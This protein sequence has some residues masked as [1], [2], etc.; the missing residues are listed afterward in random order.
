[1]N[2]PM[3]QLALCDSRCKWHNRP[4]NTNAHFAI[5]HPSIFSFESLWAECFTTL[6][7][8]HQRH[9]F[10]SATAPD[11]CC[12]NLFLEYAILL[13]F[14]PTWQALFFSWAM[15]YLLWFAVVLDAQH[16]KATISFCLIALQAKVALYVLLLAIYMLQVLIILA[17]FS[18][19]HSG[20]QQNLPSMTPLFPLLCKLGY[21]APF[22]LLCLPPANGV[23][24]IV[25]CQ[26]CPVS[27]FTCS[28]VSMCSLTNRLRPPFQI[29]LPPVSCVFCWH[30][31]QVSLTRS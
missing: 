13:V 24:Y 4:V 28:T 2:V 11:V 19:S 3:W 12:A 18:L 14:E 6:N 7:C 17:P 26:Q 15:F 27:S 23:Q 16:S 10:W 5:K 22:H 29:N 20:Q 25:C 1:M 21:Y 31:H 9:T 30:C 8:V